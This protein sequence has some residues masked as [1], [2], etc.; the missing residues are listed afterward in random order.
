[1][2]SLLCSRRHCQHG[3]LRLHAGANHDHAVRDWCKP[4]ELPRVDLPGVLQPCLGSLVQR[5]GALCKERAAPAGGAVLE[6]RDCSSLKCHFW[7]L[8]HRGA[9]GRQLPCRDA[10]EELQDDPSDVLGDC[11]RREGVWHPGL[12]R[13][14]RH[15]RR[16]DHVP[17]DWADRGQAYCCRLGGKHCH[18]LAAPG[19]SSCCRW[20]LRCDAGGALQG[21][22]DITIQPDASHQHCL[23]GGLLC[24]TPWQWGFC[25]GFHFHWHVPTRSP[26]H[27]LEQLCAGCWAMVPLWPD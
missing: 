27:R 26:R 6:V 15:H 5:V 14:G 17:V 19:C 25:E 20:L 10:G 9:E 3:P 4:V 18:R 24:H 21:V 12:A 7:C 8:H 11:C 2:G 13:C 23:S 22:Q 16:C 1:M